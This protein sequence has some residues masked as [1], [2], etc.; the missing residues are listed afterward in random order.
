MEIPYW[1]HYRS[2]VKTGFY[3]FILLGISFAIVWGLS[4]YNKSKKIE[5]IKR[6]NTK[7]F[8]IQGFGIVI[9]VIISVINFYLAVLLRVLTK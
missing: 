5:S 9:S 4:I 7:S 3:T 8:F 1:T 6:H 2:R